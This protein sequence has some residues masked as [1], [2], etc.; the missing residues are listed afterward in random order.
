MRFRAQ[1]GEVTLDC[2][3]ALHYNKNRWSEMQ[4]DFYVA[5]SYGESCLVVL[6]SSLKQ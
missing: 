1:E 4:A 5:K 3:M 6:I 2:N